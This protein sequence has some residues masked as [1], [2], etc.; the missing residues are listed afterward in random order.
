MA[1]INL[2]L[3]AA[4]ALPTCAA[5]GVT[6]SINSA[7]L[8]AI[9]ADAVRAELPAAD[10]PAAALPAFYDTTFTAAPRYATMLEIPDAEPMPVE[11]LE[12]HTPGAIHG[13]IAL[14]AIAGLTILRARP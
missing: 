12:R 13:P 2:A 10:E 4:L 3:F 11:I 6:T 1:R 8:A 14:A 5:A 9:P 7:T